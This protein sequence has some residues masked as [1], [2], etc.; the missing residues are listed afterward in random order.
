MLYFSPKTW[1][2]QL[3]IDMLSPPR[4]LPV[5]CL[6]VQ[7]LEV[8]ER[9]SVLYRNNVSPG[10][11][12]DRP[13]GRT[14]S[15]PVKIP[16]KIGA[17]YLCRHHRASRCDCN[18]VC[19][20]NSSMTPF[21]AL[22]LVASVAACSVTYTGAIVLIRRLASERANPRSVTGFRAVNTGPGAF[23]DLEFLFDDA[24][25]AAL[26]PVAHSAYLRKC[27]TPPMF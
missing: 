11:H 26:A 19:D 10:I 5:I 15:N 13:N 4:K 20:M 22:M 3:F 25:C 8:D 7:M 2:F 16:V 18:Q 9:V 24:H 14:P 23:D 27:K 17:P 12:R 6:K 1:I 21:Q